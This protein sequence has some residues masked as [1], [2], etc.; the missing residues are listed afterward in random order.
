MNKIIVQEM[1]RP[2]NVGSIGLSQPVHRNLAWKFVFSTKAWLIPDFRLHSLQ[3][4][5]WIDRWPLV[6]AALHLDSSPSF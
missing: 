4:R 2:R 5:D 3:E 6:P 1:A